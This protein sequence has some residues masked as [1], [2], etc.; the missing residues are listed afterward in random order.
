MKEQVT[1]E[2]IRPARSKSQANLKFDLSSDTEGNLRVGMRVLANPFSEWTK[3]YP[4]KIERKLNDGTFSILFDDGE[5][6]AGVEPDDIT[7]ESIS[8]T[9]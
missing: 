8:G 6:V 3:A 1:A 9:I 5:R 7:I 4:G 2:M